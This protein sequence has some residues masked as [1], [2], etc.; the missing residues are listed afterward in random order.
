MKPVP[1]LVAF[2]LLGLMALIT[3][4]CSTPEQRAELN[5]RETRNRGIIIHQDREMGR[6]GWPP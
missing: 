5:A 2:T 3:V 4:G 1:L 6:H